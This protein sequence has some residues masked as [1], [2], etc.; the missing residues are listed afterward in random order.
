[1]KNNLHSDE[2]QQIRKDQIKKEQVNIDG[3][4]SVLSGRKYM[5]EE[6]FQALDEEQKRKWIFNEYIRLQELDKNLEDERKLIEIQKGMLQRQQNKSLLLKKQLENQK[7]LFD[8]KWQILE[9]ETRQLALDKEKFNREK[10]MYKDKVYREA[11]RSMSNAENVKIFF[12]GV[13]DTDSL[14]KR[15]KALLKIY[16]PD[17]MNGDNDLLLAI[18]EE[19]EK[20]SRFYLGS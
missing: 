10:L 2:E 1:M 12:K 15:Y 7:N 9:K 16:H 18:Q 19:Y 6:R 20:L 3:M 8:Q 11:R 14:K 17:N 13:N 4:S 5:G